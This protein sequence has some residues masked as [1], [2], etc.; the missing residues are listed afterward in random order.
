MK[1]CIA[2]LL[3]LCCWL[4]META[5]YACSCGPTDVIA[6]Y[7]GAEHVL[8][9]RVERLLQHSSAARRYLA[10]LVDPDFKGCLD[11]NQHVVIETPAAS[12]GCGV[13]L[14]RTEYLL[15]GAVTRSFFGLPVLRV[16]MCDANRTWPEL[17][18]DEVAFL[19]TRDPCCG[20]GCE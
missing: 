20:E 13:T 6:S 19:V 15:Y 3:T 14:A 17:S 7:E 10:V 4:A 5:V 8:H 12:A 2:G 9:V 11:T 18:G 1:T 16:S